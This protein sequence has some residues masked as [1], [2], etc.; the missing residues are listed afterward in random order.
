MKF[1]IALA[2]LITSQTVLAAP[3]YRFWR[4]SKLPQM[5]EQSYLATMAKDFL[6]LAPKLFPHLQSY[7][8]AVPATGLGVDEVALLAYTNEEDYV[9]GR[10]TA[11]GRAYGDAHWDI[12]ERQNSVSLVPETLVGKLTSNKAYDLLKTDLNWGKG[13]TTFFI[14]KKKSSISTQQFSTGLDAHVR[15]VRQGFVPMGLKGYVILVT[16]DREYALMNWESE[17]KASKAFSTK[18]GNNVS[19]EASQL[20]ETLQWSP[21]TKFQNSIQRNKA[22]YVETK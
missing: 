6:P 14:G 17:A 4:G 15:T 19:T 12:F 18:F 20:M 1:T 7:L 22:Y 21:L 13:H 8:V 11:E 5:P 9:R 3:Y 16:E 2:L 10:A